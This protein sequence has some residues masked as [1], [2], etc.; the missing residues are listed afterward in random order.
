VFEH[1]IIDER[2][3][4]R[5]GLGVSDMPAVDSAAVNVDDE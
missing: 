1:G 4:Q 3:E 5:C 2:L